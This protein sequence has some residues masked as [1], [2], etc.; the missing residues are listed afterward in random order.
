MVS[1]EKQ[2]IMEMP[3]AFH[4]AVK[5]NVSLRVINV[6]LCRLTPHLRLI[7]VCVVLVIPVLLSRRAMLLVLNATVLPPP[8]QPNLTTAQILKGAMSVHVLLVIRASLVPIKMPFVKTIRVMASV[9]ML[10]ISA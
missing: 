4:K 5:T 9:L 8:A 3:F 10:V 7:F 6:S 2:W 1:L